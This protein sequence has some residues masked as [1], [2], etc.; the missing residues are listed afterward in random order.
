MDV[1]HGGRW[2]FG[3]FMTPQVPEL[4]LDGHEDEFFALWYAQLAG[5]THPLPPQD[6]SRY[7]D[8][9]RGREH[10]ASSFGHYRTL[11]DDGRVN[12]AWTA[13][14]NRLSMPVLAIGGAHAVGDR[15]ATN[16]RPVAPHAEAAV[17]AGSG[18]FLAEEQP[19]Q[20]TEHLLAFLGQPAPG[21]R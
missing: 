2:H 3:F 4:L 20:L 9:Y 1:A 19:A 6:V 21:Q 16:L 18:H 12:A 5:D 11:L 8:A 15:L 7:A 10:L 17:I 14:G 13:A